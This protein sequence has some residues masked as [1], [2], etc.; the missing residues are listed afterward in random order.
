KSGASLDCADKV[1]PVLGALA[2]EG[3]MS[4]EPAAPG[5]QKAPTKQLAAGKP[6]KQIESAGVKPAVAPESPPVQDVAEPTAVSDVPP[7]TDAPK[8]VPA[9]KPKVTPKATVSPKDK[10]LTPPPSGEPRGTISGTS[11]RYKT[12]KSSH[13]EVVVR[14]TTGRTPDPAASFDPYQ[15]SK[16]NV[17]GEYRFRTFEKDGKSYRQGEGRLGM[18][19]E[20]Q[21]HRDVTAQRKVSG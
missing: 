6:F 14:K 10:P 19:D 15:P 7:K 18:P 8:V 4:G 1:I 17:A 21:T 9:P 12:T 2:M 5:Q 3:L 16:A 13:P 20:V 11:G